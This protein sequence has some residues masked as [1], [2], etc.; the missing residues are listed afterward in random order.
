M[1]RMRTVSLDFLVYN[2]LLFLDGFVKVIEWLHP[3]SYLQS[4]SD[5]VARRSLP[6][7]GTDCILTEE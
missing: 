7:I 3:A 5:R 6:P 4:L 1:R 2:G